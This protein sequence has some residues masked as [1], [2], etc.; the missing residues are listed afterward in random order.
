[1]EKNRS[2]F[3]KLLIVISVLVIV[4][5][6]LILVSIIPYE[7]AW[8]GRLKTAEEMYVF[9][10]L[11][12]LIT[13]FFIFILVQKGGYM[14]TCIRPKI[15]SAILWVFF[16]LFVLNTIGN[17]FAETNFEKCFSL[18]TFMNAFF[19]WKINKVMAR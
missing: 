12:I 11:S 16:M 15:V 18:L 14:P 13:A 5:H 1:M 17:L 3:I 2:V 10:T 6:A 7:I 8:G 19:I 4:F 9:E